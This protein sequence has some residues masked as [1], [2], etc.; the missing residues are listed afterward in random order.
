MNTQ[1]TIAKLQLFCVSE[2]VKATTSNELSSQTRGQ[3]PHMCYA[4][5][6]CH[7]NCWL[8]YSLLG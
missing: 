7:S 8:V 2:D 5:C 3:L 6:Q 1:C 4:Y